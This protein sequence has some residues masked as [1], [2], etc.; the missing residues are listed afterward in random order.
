MV[1]RTGPTNNT[2]QELLVELRGKTHESRF[3]K[4]IVHDLNKPTRQRRTVNIYKIDKFARDGETIIVPGK[5]LSVGML[6]KKV[7]VAAMN[8][9]DEAR[10]KIVQA[11]GKVL[12]IK[13]LLVQNPEGKNV[14][15][16]G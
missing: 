15:I 2:V 13:E 12:S 9:S 3:W 7:D 5:V 6:S 11:K 4:R 8:F 16:L 14:R 1:R 10:S